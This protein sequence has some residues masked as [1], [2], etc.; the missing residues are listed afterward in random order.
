[1]FLLNDLAG[2]RKN[3]SSRYLVFQPAKN[4]MHELILNL[5]EGDYIWSIQQSY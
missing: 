1:M 5:H 3:N 2:L 4:Q